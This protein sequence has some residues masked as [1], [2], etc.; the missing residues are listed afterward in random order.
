[1]VEFLY[2]K[3]MKKFLITIFPFCVLLFVFMWLSFGLKGALAFFGIAIFIVILA[4]GLAKWIEF[5]D[6]HIK[7]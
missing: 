5:V 4:F 2:G 7:D 6:K 1:M 3:D